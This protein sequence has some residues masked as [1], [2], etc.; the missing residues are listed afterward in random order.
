MQLFDRLIVKMFNKLE[1]L[2]QKAKKRELIRKG[3]TLGEQ[4]WIGAHVDIISPESIVVGKKCH[5]NNYVHLHAAGGKITIGDYVTLSQYCKLIST[6]YDLE[7][8]TREKERVHI[9]G[10]EII[11]GDYVWICSSAI[12]L[13]GVKITGR[14]V[15]IAAG[16]VVTHDIAES[17]VIV[18]GVPAEI[19]KR[20]PH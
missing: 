9:C 4:S 7:H 1:S 2:E 12:I 11:I 8:W 3:F 19:I 5:I 6:G 14:H 10:Q 13:P 15:V 17:Y 16:A 20:I 18:G